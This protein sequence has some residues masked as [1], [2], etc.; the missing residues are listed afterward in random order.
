MVIRTSV[1]R[2]RVYVHVRGAK[3]NIAAV[4]TW[5]Q[6]NLKAASRYSSTS[7]HSLLSLVPEEH[8]GPPQWYVSHA[9]QGSFVDLVA[10]LQQELA[11]EPGPTEPAPP[12]GLKDG[13][14]LWIGKRHLQQPSSANDVT[15][16]PPVNS[17]DLF[18]VD[19]YSSQ[20]PAASDAM[21]VTADVLASCSEG[22]DLTGILLNSLGRQ[23]GSQ[24]GETC[25]ALLCSAPQA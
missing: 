8:V 2:S 16:G 5:D 6:M 15:P 11:P 17:T 7:L 21:R 12:K 22:E 25:L 24:F 23:P 10:G 20:S 14:F 9:R 1:G 19:L 18:A 13:I 4:E 3:Y